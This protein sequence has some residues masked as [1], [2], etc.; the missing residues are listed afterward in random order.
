MMFK[1]DNTVRPYPW[2]SPTAMAELFGR[3][4]SGGPEA[5]LWLGAHPASPSMLLRPGAE[6]ARLDDAIAADP[7][8]MLGPEARLL[9]GD[10]LPFLAKV[11]AADTPLSLQVHPT[12]AQAAAGYAAEEES[13]PARNA[14]DRNYRDTNHK[15]EMLYALSDF[16]A[17][18]GF[19][20]PDDAAT[21]FSAVAA[22]LRSHGTADSP[23]LARLRAA[24]A[25]PTAEPQRLR[26]AFELLLAGGEDVARL[27]H[28]AAAALRAQPGPG[29]TGDRTTAL[30]TVVELEDLYPA[31]P[32]VLVSL[33]LNRVRLCRGQAMYLPAGNVHAYLHGIGVEVMASSDNV[34]RGGLTA[35]HVDVPELLRTVDFTPSPAPRLEP[36]DTG[37]G[38]RLY[39]PPFDEFAL[40]HLLLSR[41]EPGSPGASM[42]GAGTAI[43]QNGPAI[44]LVTS[45]TVVLDG[46]GGDLV[47]NRGESAFIAASEAPIIASAGGDAAG[48]EAFA[49]TLPGGSGTLGSVDA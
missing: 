25:A 15:P 9:F 2:G 45:G 10:R 47:L 7:E 46:P 27:V 11:L 24:L 31:D 6:D 14:A 22:A 43:A 17:L 49:V 21:L 5:E 12:A 19:R 39:A 36:I 23:V 32:G 18:C 48:A 29:D 34:L 40:Q 44:V 8:R 20:S 42:A 4:P 28:D 41:G 33:L 1:L 38:Q 35:K 16:D 26:E 37:L 3:Q 13:G 30:E